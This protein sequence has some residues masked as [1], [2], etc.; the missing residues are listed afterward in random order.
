MQVSSSSYRSRR[1]L[2]ACPCLRNGAKGV[3]YT[4]THTLTTRWSWCRVEQSG[5]KSPGTADS[6]CTHERRGGSGGSQLLLVSVG[7]RRRTTRR[8]KEEEEK[9][10]E[11]RGSKAMTNIMIIRASR[12]LSFRV[13]LHLRLLSTLSRAAR[14]EESGALRSPT[15]C[16]ASNRK[17]YGGRGGGHVSEARAWPS[18]CP[19]QP[20]LSG[21]RPGIA[22]RRVARLLSGRENVITALWWLR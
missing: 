19:G 2:V 11:E 17:R 16:P 3:R 12:V 4:R 1:A 13:L 10:E 9:E 20:A 22:T 15:P 5:N 6:R 14:I 18:G 7:R 8:R 21:Y